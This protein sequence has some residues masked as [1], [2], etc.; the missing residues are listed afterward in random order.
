MDTALKFK[1]DAET[2]GEIKILKSEEKGHDNHPSNLTP[3]FKSALTL[4]KKN[5]YQNVKSVSV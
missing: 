5:N 3:T 2:A 4:E 1:N